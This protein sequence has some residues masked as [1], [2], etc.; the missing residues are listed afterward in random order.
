MSKNVNVNAALTVAPSTAGRRRLAPAA[1]VTR[2]SPIATMTLLWPE[3]NGI[4]NNET[5]ADAADPRAN[6]AAA[7]QSRVQARNP[8]RGEPGDP[9]GLSPREYCTSASIRT[10]DFG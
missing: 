9:A 2:T 4:Q 8:D 6:A 10:P 1:V 5:A 7:D 3:R